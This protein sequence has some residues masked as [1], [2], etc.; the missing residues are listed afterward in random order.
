MS[1]KEYE[2][3]LD[4]D[5]ISNEERTSSNEETEN[6]GEPSRSKYF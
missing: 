4:D 5:I 2:F 6:D 3:L 1:T